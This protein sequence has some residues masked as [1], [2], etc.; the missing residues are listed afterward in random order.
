M[1][2]ITKKEK[3]EITLRQ[4]FRKRIIGYIIAAFGLV[5]G[6]AWNDAVKGLIE[7]LFPV[8]Q[9]GMAAKFIYAVIITLVLVIVTVYL[10]RWFVSEE[11][12]K[13]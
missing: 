4:E 11:E 2:E 6:L 3:K 13:K 9:N 5:A 8:S 1:A 12:A 7:Y 10:T